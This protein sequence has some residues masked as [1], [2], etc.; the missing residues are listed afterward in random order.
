[1][2]GRYRLTTKAPSLQDLLHAGFEDRPADQ[3]WPLKLRYNAAPTQTLP[4]VRREADGRRHLRLL[5]WGL[6]PTW[7]K[8]GSALEAGV[9]NARIETL[10]E[11]P[12]FR[13]LLRTHRCLVP[14]NGFY[15]WRGS[16][17]H[18]TPFLFSYDDDRVVCFGGLWSGST[19]AIVTTPP[20][21]VVAPFH[22]RMPLIIKPADH[23]RWLG[24]DDVDFGAFAV[25]GAL[26]GL[27]AR[28]VSPRLGNVDNDDDGVLLPDVELF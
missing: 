18:K 27:V 4:V 12:A 15:E 19:F 3:Q 6:V 11:K 22:D 9:I 5:R 17:K 2:C 1:M 7:A 10:D 8:E 16:G 20:N 28:R 21:D 23:E 26:L 13:D 14:T 25:P 24:Y